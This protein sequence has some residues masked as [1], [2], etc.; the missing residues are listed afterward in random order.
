MKNIPV[1]NLNANK[2]IRNYFNLYFTKNF[3]KSRFLGNKIQRGLVRRLYVSNLETKHRNSKII[4]TLYTFNLE[5]QKLQK[6]YLENLRFFSQ[7]IIIYLKKKL[8]KKISDFMIKDVEK[9]NL[10]YDEYKNTENKKDLYIYKYKLLSES[11]N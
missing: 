9:K 10:V 3:L 4:M 2:I 5:K 11:M 1:N 7:N 8:R 6:Q